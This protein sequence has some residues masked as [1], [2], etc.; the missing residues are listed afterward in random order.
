MP[1][2]S[3]SNSVSDMDAWDKIGGPVLV[4]DTCLCFNALKELP[5]PYMS[6][7]HSW[8]RSISQKRSLSDQGIENGFSKLW[9]TKA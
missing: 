2:V 4:E 8:T 1:P 3:D 6:V 7:A 9:A 5:G